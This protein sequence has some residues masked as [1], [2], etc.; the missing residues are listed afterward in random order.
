[1]LGV[2]FASSFGL[3]VESP[4]WPAP[5]VLRRVER[6]ILLNNEQQQHT[7]EVH[8]SVECKWERVAMATACI[9]FSLACIEVGDTL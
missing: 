2:T 5:R 4:V 6:R 7:E 1:M 8:G 9:G 3:N